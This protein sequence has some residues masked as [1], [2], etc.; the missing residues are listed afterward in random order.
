MAFLI[1]RSQ[2]TIQMIQK[3][4]FEF[5]K[6]IKINNNKVWFDANKK[7]YDEARTAFITSVEEMKTAIGSLDPD[8]N[9]LTAKEC[10]FRMNRDIRFSKDKRPYKNNMAAYFNRTGKKGTGAGYYV[11][12]EPGQSFIAAGV[13]MPEGDGLSKI[14]QE[15]DYNFDEWKK[16][17]G[18]A[19]FK[20]QF[21]NGID[22]SNSLIR[23][24]KGYDEKN[25]AL[26]FL[27]LKSFVAMKQISDVELKSKTFVNDLT[28]SFKTVKPLIDFINRSLD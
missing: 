8:I 3:I 10:I 5:L 16:I 17:I 4:T 27:K 15:I 23:P 9:N 26:E 14:R 20:K 11:H 24:P 12:V 19:S 7:R 22:K 21:E 28:K 1:L 25:P 6:D 13:W 2:S 18:S